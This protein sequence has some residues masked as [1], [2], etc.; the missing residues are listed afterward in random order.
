MGAIRVG[1]EWDRVVPAGWQEAL[2]AAFPPS[3]HLSSF[4]LIWEPGDPWQ[5]IQRWF[6]WQMR[7]AWALAARPDIL[8][9]LEGPHPR[10]TGHYCA[11]GWCLCALKT[12]AW[13][14]GPRVE[15]AASVDR[16]A[17]EVYRQTGAYGVR[18]WTLQGDHGGHRHR[19]DA[20]ERKIAKLYGGASETPAPGDLPYAE[21]DRRALAKFLETDRVNRW[22]GLVRFHERGGAVMD[23][24]ARDLAERAGELMW[25][26]LES[27]VQK[28]SDTTS[29]AGWKAIADTVPR[30]PWAAEPRVDLD[31]ERQATVEHV[32]GNLTAA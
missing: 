2:D 26:W 23:A 22:K 29:K 28:I 1:F 7:P 5:P 14:D 19:L 6:V 24:E 20:V 3:E 17:W 8:K 32:A 13:R 16:L 25:G 30:T 21:F 31:A 15:G 12:N 11:A 9:A 4:R 10:S 18:W 27:Q